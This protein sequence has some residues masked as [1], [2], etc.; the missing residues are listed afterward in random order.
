LAWT[1]RNDRDTA[2]R[3]RAQRDPSEDGADKNAGDAEIDVPRH[4]AGSFVLQIVRQALDC[5]AW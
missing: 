5:S 2:W 1:V 4:R 3:E